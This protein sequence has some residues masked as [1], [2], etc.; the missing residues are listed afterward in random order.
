[1]KLRPSLSKRTEPSGSA[2]GSSQ[3]FECNAAQRKNRRQSR[4]ALIGIAVLALQVGCAS[5]AK[6]QAVSESQPTDTPIPFGPG[7]TVQSRVPGGYQLLNRDLRVVV[8]DQTGDVIWFGTN[9]RN[10]LGKTGIRAVFDNATETKWNGFIEARDEQ[11]WQFFGDNGGLRWR[12][13]YCLEGDHLYASFIVQN[14]TRS[15]VVGRIALTGDLPAG[16]LLTHDFEHCVVNAAGGVVSLRGWNLEHDRTIVPMPVW[17][18]SDP[19]AIPAG[20]R[21]AYTTDWQFTPAGGS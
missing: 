2:A 15:P 19:L 16:T 12:K 7:P 6:T 20:E 21:L 11:T 14:M 8:S 4:S 18:A 17:I 3:A 1:M 13:I 9:D 5:P 10:Q